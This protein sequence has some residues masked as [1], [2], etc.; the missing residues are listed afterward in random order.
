LAL[1]ISRNVLLLGIA[2][3]PNLITLDALARQIA[4]SAAL[5]FLASFADLREELDHGILGDAR[6]A[7]SGANGIALDESGYNLCLLGRS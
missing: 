7:Y 2:E 5:I 3:R 6:H 1:L 4:K